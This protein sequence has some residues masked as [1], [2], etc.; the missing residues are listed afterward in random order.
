MRRSVFGCFERH[1]RQLTRRHWTFYVWTLTDWCTNTS[2]L[3]TILGPRVL[4]VVAL[5]KLTFTYLLL[6]ILTGRSEPMVRSSLP[7]FT[8]IGATC[9]P[10]GA[11]NPK[12]GPWVKTIPEEL[13]FEQILPVK[14]SQ[15][16]LSHRRASFD[17]HQVLHDDRGPPCHHCTTLTF[18]DPISSS[19]QGHRKFGWNCPHRV[20]VFIILSLIELKQ[21]NL[22]ELCRLRTRT[23]RVNFVRIVQGTHRLKSVSTTRVHGPSSRADNSAREL[24]PWTRVVE[25][26]L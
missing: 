12:I 3:E 14:T 26:D 13:P 4:C 21:P 10:C 16:T 18:L 11:K 19:A 7:N 25:T 17:F 23:N 8:L 2:A 20:N 24:E 9:R 22:T 5:Y 15:F 6:T 1:V